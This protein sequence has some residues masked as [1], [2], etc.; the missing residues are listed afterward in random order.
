MNSFNGIGNVVA[1]PEVHAYKNGKGQVAKFRIAVTHKH[2][3]KAKGYKDEET[4]YLVCKAFDSE[5]Y[6]RGTLCAERLTKGQKVAVRGRLL[7]EAW[8]TKEGESRSQVVLTVDEVT[9]LAAKG[10]ERREKDVVAVNEPRPAT[11]EDVEAE[12]DDIP[13]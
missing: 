7:T 4:C 2:G 1:A 11:K 13:F 8:K 5:G 6:S 9:F 12:T 10:E 3:T